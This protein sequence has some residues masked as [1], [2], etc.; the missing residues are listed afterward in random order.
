MYAL[1]LLLGM[2][3]QK[4]HTELV[5]FENYDKAYGDRALSA[6]VMV[7]KHGLHL[8]SSRLVFTADFSGFT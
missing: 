2:I 5:L 8:Y 7:E 4:R 1:P 3:E 6:T